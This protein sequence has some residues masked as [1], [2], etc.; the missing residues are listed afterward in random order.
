MELCFFLR[1]KMYK[2]ET[3]DFKN[4]DSML[5]EVF[6]YLDVKESFSDWLIKTKEKILSKYD[7]YKKTNLIISFVILN[8]ELEKIDFEKR[9]SGFSSWV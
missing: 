2:D 7:E 4:L 6:N 8:G 3:L 9:Y 1:E 5:Q